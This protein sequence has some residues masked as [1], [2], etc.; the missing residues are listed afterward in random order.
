MENEKIAR[1]IAE[2]RKEKNLTQK[3][4]ADKLGITDKAV[5]KWERGLSCPDISLLST[6]SEI[7]G[8]TT[9]ELLSGEKSAAPAPEVESIVETALAYADNTVKRKSG[10]VRVI[11]A[12]TFSALSLIGIITCL[13]CDFA[14]NGKLT[15]GLIPVTSILFLWFVGM[16][17]LLWKKK[18]SLISL[19]LF[20]L[21]TIPF[22]YLLEKAIGNGV[23]LTTIGIKVSIVGFIYLWILYIIYLLT[24]KRKL[25]FAGIA[26]LTVIPFGFIVNLILHHIM[27]EPLTDVWDI[28]SYSVL[29]IT[30]FALFVIDFIKNRKRA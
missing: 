16:P 14:I 9:T 24:Q 13:I 11:C 17:V 28:F 25:I 5:S 26:V 21:L 20:T 10:R 19:I 6:L 7:L 29:A 27:G 4:L 3:E 23:S 15:W 22:L 12:I 30:A 2:L 18:G 8:I 1:L